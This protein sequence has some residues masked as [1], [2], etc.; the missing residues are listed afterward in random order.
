MMG[1]ATDKRGWST[2]A[3]FSMRRACCDGDPK[4]LTANH[5]YCLGSSGK[6]IC[7]EEL[8]F[9]NYVYPEMPCVTIGRMFIRNYVY[10]KMYQ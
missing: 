1:D 9:R 8:Y 10:P 6:I 5:N 7:P 2:S 4:V 3:P